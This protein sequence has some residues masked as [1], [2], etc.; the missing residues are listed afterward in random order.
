[1]ILGL[2]KHTENQPSIPVTQT[3]NA[4]FQ[5]ICAA[6]WVPHALTG[7]TSPQLQEPKPN[8]GIGN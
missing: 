1:M 8:S 6:E 3:A 2:K 5:K 7:Q 4:I